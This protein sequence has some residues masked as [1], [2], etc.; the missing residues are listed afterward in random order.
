[1]EPAAGDVSSWRGAS[2]ARPCDLLDVARLGCADEDVLVVMLFLLIMVNLLD[3]GVL[4]RGSMSV[5]LA[6][7]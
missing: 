7:R 6:C 4:G 2:G 3:D 5:N 1:M